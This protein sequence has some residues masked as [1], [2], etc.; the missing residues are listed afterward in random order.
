MNI[1]LLASGTGTNAEKLIEHAS[2]LK[3]ISIV[4]IVVDQASSKLLNTKRSVPVVLIE[5]IEGQKK[6]DH[7]ENILRQLKVW[8]TDWVLLAGYMR[9]LSKKFL[10]QYKNKVVNI[11]PSLLP[12]YP[13]AHAY[14]RAFEDNVTES[15]VTVH[16]VDEGIDTGKVWRQETF[17]KFPHD[18]LEDFIAR[19][20]NVE[21]SL[22]PS[23][24]DWLSKNNS[25]SK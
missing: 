10:A 18:S 22:Y 8:N 6:S 24:L 9:L 20:K 16:F 25:E 21:W 19:G 11:H 17:K 5:K 15:G 12:L 13:G 4:G 1:A 14:E 3:N 2:T 23:F 7:E